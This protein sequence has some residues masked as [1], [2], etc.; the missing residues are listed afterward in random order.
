MLVHVLLNEL[1]ARQLIKRSEFTCAGDE[2]YASSL[3]GGEHS[4]S[5]AITH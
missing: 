2:F 3:R 5:D 1:C 4:D